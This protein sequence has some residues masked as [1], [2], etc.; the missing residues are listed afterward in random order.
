MVHELGVAECAKVFATCQTQRKRALNLENRHRPSMVTDYDAIL[1]LCA[2]RCQNFRARVDGLLAS[3]A[4]CSDLP[5]GLGSGAALHAHPAVV[6]L[7]DACRSAGVHPLPEEVMALVRAR[8]RALDEAALLVVMGL[9]ATDRAALATLLGYS[10]EPSQPAT[11]LESHG[12]A[13]AQRGISGA[14][15]TPLSPR[16]EADD[17]PSPA[18]WQQRWVHLL[19]GATLALLIHGILQLSSRHYG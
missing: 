10:T 14:A 17:A 7:T 1:S 2:R 18:L 5:A 16:G 3:L 19:A 6:A 15:T 11:H 8:R 9:G 4:A 12:A 13:G